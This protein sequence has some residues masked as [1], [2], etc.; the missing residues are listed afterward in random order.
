M[1][2]NCVMSTL[3]FVFVS[4]SFALQAQ[5]EWQTKAEQQQVFIK[6]KKVAC[7]DEANGIFKE[8]V[9]LQLENTSNATVEVVFKKEMWFNNICNNC[10][11]IHPSI[12]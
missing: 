12:R 9:M 10:D 5:S 11:K 6:E 1:I 8:M 3:L 2:K 7:N 4:I